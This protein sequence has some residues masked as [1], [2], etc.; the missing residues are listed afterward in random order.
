MNGRSACAAIAALT[1][2]ACGGGDREVEPPEAPIPDAVALS[3]GAIRQA[4]VVEG[5][6][7][8]GPL[9]LDL[10]LAGNIAFDENR[11]SH[12]APRIGGRVSRILADYGD[13]V[14]SGQVLAEIDAPE[15]GQALADY[16]KARSE[17]EVKRAEVER[18]R[19]L[20][21]GKAISQSEFLA[22]ENQHRIAASEAEY[23]ENRLHLL[24]LGQEDLERLASLWG[25]DVQ[26]GFPVR[27]PISGRIIT[28][29]INPGEIVPSGQELFVVGDI[30]RVWIFLQVHERDLPHVRAG[31]AVRL[32]ADAYPTDTFAG[33]IDFVGDELE[34]ATRTARAR[35]VIENADGRLKPG[36]F[37]RAR[38]SVPVTEPVLHVE[39]GA[40]QEI[41]GAGFVFIPLGGGRFG[42]REVGVGRS[43]GGRTEIVSGLA[44]DEALVTRGAF[45]LKSQ[46]LRATL[47]GED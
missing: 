1:L 10:E 14:A 47:A 43:S 25:R 30:S 3:E 17:L 38:V 11:V 40:I 6:P 23:A 31:L 42:R 28:R 4:E 41:G 45:W 37:A 35:A 8:W 18:A 22:R 33:R 36:M 26:A 29:R 21:E 24:G 16:Q 32:A 27:A 13:Q 20:L 2:A 44:G 5:K 19:L 7:S 46:L 15:V 39:E 9:L 34:P 12:I